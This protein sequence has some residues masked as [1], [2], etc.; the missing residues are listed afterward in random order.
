[1]SA[2]NRDDRA[3]RRGIAFT[4]EGL[5]T[6]ALLSYV[7]VYASHAVSMSPGSLPA[8]LSFPPAQSQ[9]QTSIA[10]AVAAA[11]SPVSVT[12]ASSQPR[13]TPFLR[14]LAALT[15]PPGT[16]QPT[17]REL[18]RQA[19]AANFSGHYKTGPGRF[20]DQAMTISLVAFGGSNF[21]FH[22]NLSG[23]I[24]TPVDPA[25]NSPVG[26]ITMFPRNVLASGAEFSVDLTGI[27]NDAHGLP[28]VFMTVADQGQSGGIALSAA[29]SPGLPVPVTG[30]GFF[31]IHYVPLE[32]HNGFSSGLF[33]ATERAL[34]YN[35]ETLN[36]I[37]NVGNRPGP[38]ALRPN[39]L[40]TPG[41]GR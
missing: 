9:S 22:T 21:S 16:P 35:S 1:M 34:Y 2:R 39:A 17:D 10:L 37:G 30:M 13:V 28:S 4:V 14:Q 5:E 24:Y 25:K 41:T 33:Y 7:D 31:K 18:I 12:A 3:V 32:S 20:S 40:S 11:A 29:N 15:Y 19:V 6:R 8:H 23:V 26:L 38:G 27:Q 36:T